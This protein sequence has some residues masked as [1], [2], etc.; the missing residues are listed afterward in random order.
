MIIGK[1]VKL[2]GVEEKHLKKLMG[3]RNNPKFRQYYREYRIL[4]LE[5]KHKWWKDKILNDDSWQFFV[6]KPIR[7]W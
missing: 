2:M 3:W 5:D 1:K 7:I 4:T 6:V